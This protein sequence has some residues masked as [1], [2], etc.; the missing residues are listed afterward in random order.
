TTQLNSIEKLDPKHQQEL[1]E[2]ENNLRKAESKYNENLSKYNDPNTSP[3]EKTKA[4]I[5]VNEAADEIK[6]LKNKLKYNPLVNLER[7]NYLDD[8]SKLTAGNAPELTNEP[9]GRSSA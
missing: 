1:L 9:R 8:I 2:L 3:E 6:K 5:L 7:Y 4:M